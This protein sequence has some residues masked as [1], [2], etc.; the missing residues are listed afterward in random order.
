MFEDELYNVYN[1][2]MKC[3]QWNVW[4]QWI[5]QLSLKTSCY[6]FFEILIV[7]QTIVN[8]LFHVIKLYVLNQN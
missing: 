1:E 8:I 5:L 6:W 4:I 2:F 3:V 7:A